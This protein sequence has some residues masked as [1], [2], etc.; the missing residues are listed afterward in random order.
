MSI[1]ADVVVIGAGMAGMAVAAH[2]AEAANVVVLEMEQQPAFHS[3]GRS[4]ATYIENYGNEV[5]RG[6]N[7]ASARFLNKPDPEFWHSA[8][9]K[10]RGLIYLAMAG[11]GDALNEMLAQSSDIVEISLEEAKARLPILRTE[12]LS[13]TLLEEGVKDIDVDAM[14]SGY[15]RLLRSRDGQIN[16]SAEV[17][18]LSRDNNVWRVETAKES[19]EAPVVVNAAGAWVDKIA[20]KAG[21]EP[22]GFTPKR[23]S[24]ATIPVPE[25]NGSPDAWPLCAEIGESFYFKSD[26]GKLL[27]SPADETPVEPHDAFADDMAIAE[28]LHHFSE[29]TTIEVSRVEHTWGGLRT[30]SADKSH[31]IGFDPRTEGFFW[32]AGQ[33]GYGIQSGE[34]GARSA[35]GLILNDALPASVESTG[36]SSAVLAPDR[37]LS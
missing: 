32:F 24:V 25:E 8:L 6:L 1:K 33:G 7:R 30:F 29:A 36:L 37:F 18:S 11:N 20:A 17:T 34:G 23:R 9:L 27:V 31:V 15:R 16:C 12:V 4:V 22:L 3:T 13:R 35:A 21:L 5:V 28:G 10:D 19:F 14:F 26:A 2:V